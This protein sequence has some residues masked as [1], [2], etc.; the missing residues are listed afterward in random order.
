MKANC[1]AI[2]ELEGYWN[3]KSLPS[4]KAVMPCNTPLLASEGN[5][6][7]CLGKLPVGVERGQADRKGG[8]GK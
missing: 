4:I 6:D 5:G 3:T 7:N 8:G 2:R 1:I